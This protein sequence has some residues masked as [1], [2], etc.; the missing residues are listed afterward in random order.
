MKYIQERILKMF[1]DDQIH[2]INDTEAI[3]HVVWK[4]GPQ[5]FKCFWT[6]N[7]TI[8]SFTTLMEF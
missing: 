8:E 4:T 6:N 2:L 1:S 7:D 3:E 5:I